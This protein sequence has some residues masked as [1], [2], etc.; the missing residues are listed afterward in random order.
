MIVTSSL[1][2]VYL[3]WQLNYALSGLV[4]QSDEGKHN[5]GQGGSTPP[6]FGHN[7]PSNFHMCRSISSVYL[8]VFTIKYRLATEPSSHRALTCS[9][10]SMHTHIRVRAHSIYACMYR[11]INN[12]YIAEARVE[13]R[14]QN[15]TS[16]RRTGRRA[17]KPLQHMTSLCRHRFV[18]CECACV[19]VCVHDEWECVYVVTLVRTASLKARIRP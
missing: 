4:S 18:C 7:F 16:Q 17:K 6:C 2:C 19:C 10:L 3:W 15:G 9:D 8:E 5:W 1:L 11:Y 13:R 14:T 12:M